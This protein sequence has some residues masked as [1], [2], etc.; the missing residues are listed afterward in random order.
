MQEYLLD[1][2]K[3]TACANAVPIGGEDRIRTCGC[4]TTLAFQAST[5]DHSDTS[6][7]IELFNGGIIANIFLICKFLFE[8]HKETKIIVLHKNS[9]IKTLAKD[10]KNVTI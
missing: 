10:F 4:V 5:L 7:Y 1:K 8:I 9:C 2:N 3:R 6:P